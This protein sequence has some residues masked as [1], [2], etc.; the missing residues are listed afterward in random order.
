MQILSK[1]F[2]ITC[3][4]LFIGNNGVGQEVDWLNTIIIEEYRGHEILVKEIDSVG[5]RCINGR[6]RVYCSYSE[7]LY[8]KRVLEL[9][10][11]QNEIVTSYNL[12]VNVSDVQLEDVDKEK[13][14]FYI[15]YDFDLMNV[16]KERTSLYYLKFDFL[17]I[18]VQTNE[19]V[20]RARA[21]HLKNPF[22]ALEQLLEDIKEFQNEGYTGVN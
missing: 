21:E 16:A 4:A 11:Q 14:R 20:G 8:D 13:V 5:E 18:D 10:S 2:W 1:L 3:L 22:E 7:Q 19:I 9:R 12:S 6:K 15:D 17:V